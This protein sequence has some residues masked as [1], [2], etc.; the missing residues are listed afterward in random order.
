MKTTSVTKALREVLFDLFRYTPQR[1]VYSDARKDGAA[2]GVKFVGLK[3]TDDQMDD[4]RHQMELRGFTHHYSRTNAQG[5]TTGTRF[6]YSPPKVEIVKK[7]KQSNKTEQSVVSSGIEN[8]VMNK[9]KFK[10]VCMKCSR[11]QLEQARPILEAYGLVMVQ[12]DRDRNYNYLINNLG[13]IPGDVSNFERSTDHG[14]AVI[15]EWDLDLFL[16]YCGIETKT[17]KVMSTP[18]MYE[19]H[20]KDIMKIHD[21]A[22]DA[23]KEIITESCISK[24]HK[25][26]LTHTF[27]QSDVDKMFRAA[28]KKQIPV[29]EQVFGKQVEKI[30]WDKIKT[31]SKVKIKYSGQ[32]CSGWR[33]DLD[34]TAEVDVVFFGT[35]HQLLPNGTFSKESY[36][37]HYFTFH[38]YDDK[39][40]KFVLFGSNHFDDCK[41][42]VVEVIE[43]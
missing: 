24:V 25:L 1:Q 41:S 2:V 6:C 19:V 13:S 28:T 31:G 32:H 21:I 30:E 43:Y 7:P 17:T 33:W 35:N 3:L 27:F 4:V 22:C 10:P 15:E 14:R 26:K 34:E 8:K 23:W 36:Y 18:K 42:F 29:L 9:E 39:T 20:L 11:E 37:N 40:D 38:A 12:I 16:Q 5:W